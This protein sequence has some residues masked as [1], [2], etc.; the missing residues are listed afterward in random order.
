MAIQAKYTP[1]AGLQQDLATGFMTGTLDL[2][3]DI[4]LTNTSKGEDAKTF[5]LA[6]EAA[7]A[8]P[9]DTVLA[10]FTGTESAVT[11][12]I[13]PNDGTNNAAAAVNITT[14]QV[15]SLISSGTV[16]GLNVTVTDA[17]G[18]RASQTATGGGA[19]NVANAGEGDN[20]VAEFSGTHLAQFHVSGAGITA[21][22]ETVTAQRVTIQATAAND[23][24]AGTSFTL[25][26]GDGKAHNFFVQS[27]G[28]PPLPAGFVQL[29][30]VAG[31]T[32]AQTGSDLAGLIDDVAGF[33]ASA[34]G[35]GL[36][37]VINDKTGVS[38]KPLQGT[39]TLAIA[40]TKAGSG[41]NGG[42]ISPT[43]VTIIDAI[44]NTEMTLGDLTAAQI[45]TMKLIT[46][47]AAGQAGD[48]ADVTITSHDGGVAEEKRFGAGQQLT[49]IWLGTQWADI[50]RSGANR[51]SATEP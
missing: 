27:A 17:K 47:L 40:D 43:G 6:I 34:D 38:A 5:T 39:T 24:P 10:V 16:P 50:A 19:Q 20:V 1:T 29:N 45:G 46:R 30:A 51:N 22:L 15:A 13:T 11:L 31:R 33:S 44:A 14:A 48:N 18:L 8:N 25:Y 21:K 2:T 35:A 42:V 32:V 36:I 28:A 12:T 41:T 7:A 26:D 4:V 9:A 3:A 49:L 37:T 23:L